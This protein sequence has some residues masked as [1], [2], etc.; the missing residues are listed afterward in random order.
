MPERYCNITMASE[1]GRLLD[2]PRA[3]EEAKVRYILALEAQ[4]KAQV[5][6]ISNAQRK[7]V[8]NFQEK[9]R[10]SVIVA[11]RH[12]KWK[13]ESKTAKKVFKE[14]R[15]VSA[16]TFKRSEHNAGEATVCEAGKAKLKR[17][18]KTT[19]A[20]SQWQ[21]RSLGKKT[22]EGTANRIDRTVGDAREI[23]LKMLATE[24]TVRAYSQGNELEQKTKCCH[25]P[26]SGN[27]NERFVPRKLMRVPSQNR[28]L[29]IINKESIGNQV[30]ESL[31]SDR[32]DIA[33]QNKKLDRFYAMDDGTCSNKISCEATTKL[34]KSEKLMQQNSGTSSIKSSSRNEA[35]S[36]KRGQSGDNSDKSFQEKPRGNKN[37]SRKISYEM[38][39]WI[40]DIQQDVQKIKNAD[41]NVRF[42]SSVKRNSS[43]DSVK[44]SQSV[45][46]VDSALEKF[47][48]L[49][50]AMR[51]SCN[52]FTTH[53]SPEEDKWAILDASSLYS[54]SALNDSRL[55]YEQKWHQR[56]PRNRKLKPGVLL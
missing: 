10:S 41:E 55:D 45:E 27:S 51:S 31:S 19:G 36:L 50:E 53:K 33:F 16:I 40:C 26:L 15:A 35:K 21:R 2:R 43:E 44:S 56:D 39:S 5:L 25:R 14:R 17:R 6:F 38:K 4:K 18:P 13:H 48:S 24:D 37:G 52:V 8:T 34:A 30:E 28:T 23:R 29:E 47:D 9:L 49:I 46:I 11:Q 7:L 20:I 54:K 1:M 42:R 22:N 32:L 12:A 3:F